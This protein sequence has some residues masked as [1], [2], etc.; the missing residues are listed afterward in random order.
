MLLLE[1]IPH[2][3]DHRNKIFLKT[4]KLYILT[5]RYILDK[6]AIIC[7]MEMDVI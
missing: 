7:Q 1:N 6:L 4:P 2:H 3:F 5:L